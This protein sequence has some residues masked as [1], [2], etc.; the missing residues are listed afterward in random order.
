MVW[1]YGDKVIILLA[2]I[3]QSKFEERWVPNDSYT[4]MHRHKQPQNIKYP[5]E[6]EKWAGSEY[7]DAVGLN[8]PYEW[9]CFTLL[10]LVMH[11]L[12]LEF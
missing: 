9:S 8:G 1:A 3:R 4:H 12:E 11:I 5:W 6:I 10:D 2:V 7:V